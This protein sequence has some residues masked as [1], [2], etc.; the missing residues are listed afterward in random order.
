MSPESNE[1]VTVRPGSLF[2]LLL[3]SVQSL[4]SVSH[5]SGKAKVVILLFLLGG[6]TPL[7]HKHTAVHF[8][9]HSLIFLIFFL[10]DKCNDGMSIGNMLRISERHNLKC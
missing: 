1:S 7:A 6:A 5:F 8:S 3:H 10:F 4:L 9:L 2:Q